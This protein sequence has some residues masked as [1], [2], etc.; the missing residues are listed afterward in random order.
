M[1]FS[2]VAWMRKLE[3]LL[4]SS[5]FGV[6]GCGAPTSEETEPPVEQVEPEPEPDPLRLGLNDVS[7]LVPLPKGDEDPSFL[8]ASDTGARG[9]L[10]PK[11]LFDTI[12]TFPVL[13]KEGLIYDRLRVVSLR[14]D[15]CG[16]DP[17]SCA[18]ELRL[19]MQPINANGTSRD[20][21]LHVFYRVDAPIFQTIVD[22]LRGLRALAPEATVEGPLDVHPA[23]LAQGV[24]GAYGTGLRELVLAHAGEENLVRMTFFLRAP[25]VNDVWF[26]GGLEPNADG[27]FVAMTIVG[28]GAGNQRVI[29]TNDSTSFGYEL[30]PNSL[31]PED[32]RAFYSTEAMNAATDEKRQA[33]MASYL[34]VENPALYAPDQL[35][36]AGCH[37]STFVTAEASRRFGL[38]AAD[39]QTDA[40]QNAERDLSLRGGA[41]LNV[42]SMRAFGY[43]G[44]EP[45]IARRTVNDTA[46]VLD[47]IE[48]KF[49]A[50]K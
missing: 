29:L 47:A 10:L 13:P 4:V 9:V 14:F 35:H 8:A 23:L 31:K 20:S 12:P 2:K 6:L 33:T 1:T 36:C 24:T 41:E 3:A 17:D 15:G 40:Y 7:V 48:A 21:A 43:F 39:F 49:P 34:R 26:F 19:V 11:S 46:A 37:L 5:C 18:P 50:S 25:P 38:S 16:G 44:V 22:G 42:R 27:E 45:M 30:T 28:V 32:G